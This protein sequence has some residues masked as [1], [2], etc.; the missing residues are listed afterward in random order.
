MLDHT[1]TAPAG[2]A[3][4]YA[5]MAERGVAF[6]HAPV[7]MSPQMCRDASGL[8]LT[9]GPEALHLRA[10]PAL[11]PMSRR[12]SATATGWQRLPARYSAGQ[13]DVALGLLAM[14]A[15]TRSRR[16]AALA[17]RLIRRFDPHVIITD[18]GDA[19]LVPAL[20]T[21]ARRTDTPPEF[22]RE[23]VR[24]AAGKRPVRVRIGM[25]SGPVVVGN[26]GA[27]GRVN[28]TVVG[29]AVNVAQRFEQ[30]GKEFMKPEDEVVLLVS[31]GTIA[32]VK[33]RSS[34]G[35]E[36]PEPEYRSIKGHDQPVE[37]YR[38]A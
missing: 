5:A 34:L 33:N 28:Y 8:M 27:P 12:R 30:L 6:L 2:T 31:G 35:I 3:A 25:H 23:V 38:L 37:V 1:T 21:L 10:T 36:L 19:F 14:W 26:I 15:M 17:S 11:A 29:D 9:S 22:D 7:F 32:A 13:T 18:W 16:Y 24:R 4:R 20:L